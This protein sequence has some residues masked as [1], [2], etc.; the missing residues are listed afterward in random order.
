MASKKKAE[1]TGAPKSAPKTRA[2][3]AKAAGKRG[4][5]HDSARE[6]QPVAAP[7]VPAPTGK[8]VVERQIGGRTL[9]LET[10]RMAKLSDGAVVARYGDTMVLAAVNSAK[11]P[12]NIDFFPLT[13]D[14]REKTSAAGMIPGGF[15]KR[16]GR[17]TTKEILGSRLIDRSIRPMFPDGF[18]RDVQVL[19]QVLSTDRENDPDVVAAIASFAALA[20]SSLPHG[21]PLGMVRIGCLGDKLTINPLWSE[22]Q[23]ADNRLNL[24]VAGHKDAIVMVEAGAKEIS[25]ETMVEALDLAHRTVQEI[26]EMVEELAQKAGKPKMAYT[27]PARDEQLFKA[28]DAEFGDEL[29]AAPL[30]P[31]TKQVRS[32]ATKAAKEKVV[33]RF[34]APANATPDEAK[35][36]EKKLAG[37]LDDIVKGSERESILAGRRADGRDTK[38]VRPITIEVGVLPRVHGSVLFTRGETQALGVVTLGSPDDQQTVDGLMPEGKKRFL[39][40]YAFPPFSVGE[41]KKMLAPGRREIGH[42]ALAERGL[43]AVLPNREEFPYTI[44]ITSEILESNGSSSM[45]TACAGTL[46]MMDAG[47]KIK[48][49]VAGIAM[50]LVMEGKRYSILSDILGSEDACG[51]MDFKVVGTGRGI[52]ALQMDIKCDGLTRAIMSEALEQA[53]QGRLH[54]LR[55]MLKALRSPRQDISPNAPRLESVQVPSEKIG[56]IIGPGGKNIRSLQEQFECKIS[57]EDGGRCTIAG[58]NSE[59][60]KACLEHIRSMTAE[61]EL[62]AVYEGRVTAIKE[63]G[64]FVE[65]LPGQEGLVHVSE[66]SD[67]FIRAVTDVVRIGDTLKVKVIAID[68]FGKVKLSRKAILLAEAGGAAAPAAPAS[69]AADAP[70]AEHGE[71]RDRPMREERGPRADRPMREERGP[72]EDRPMR[73]ER[74][75]RADRPMR[76][77][78]GPREDRPMRD[79]RGP[80]EDRPMREERGPRADRPMREERGPREDRPMRDERG[81][82]EDRPMRDERGPRED[83]PMRDER[84]PRADRPMREERG[85]R[86]DRP[87]R[88]ERG[89]REDRPMREERSE[90][91]VPGRERDWGA[92]PAE[93]GHRE[94][95]ARDDERRERGRPPFADEG[96]PRRERSEGEREPR[97]PSGRDE[98]RFDRGERAEPA[99]RSERRPERG[100][101]DVGENRER[102][103]EPRGAREPRGRGPAEPVEPVGFDSEERRP[104]REAARPPVGGERRERPADR[105][106]RDDRPRGP[107]SA[108]PM[109]EFDD[110]APAPRAGNDV[111]ELESLDAVLGDRPPRRDGGRRGRRR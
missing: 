79:E 109:A 107:R 89:P 4:E 104:Q 61:I 25:E 55:E 21:M 99:E 19:S 36:W 64:A 98:P 49:P 86:A 22:L 51:D 27:P 32:A 9:S 94:P 35:A 8:V 1:D 12:D 5:H 88:E 45:A 2:P 111:G 7:A 40:H 53:K 110:E 31:G 24:T 84:G 16:E 108:M 10:G 46:A 44:R 83:R 39:L 63:F 65:I 106:G 30:T 59:K 105:G 28:I 75:P 48:Q 96:A 20:L 101:R 102:G 100:F 41:V 34:K 54:I 47:V 87:M 6:D 29:R 37:L 13:V 76:E 62:G 17:P 11:A 66:L 95:R 58:L 42:G 70:S 50:G 72:R 56:L 97:R 43:E 33:N 69:P 93:R 90:R 80:R 85:P 15:F 3:R 73:E 60:V 78:R 91:P 68:D 38:T 103:A 82:R 92:E 52:T 14:Y 23:S 77:E 74:G 26:V 67:G 18:R 71:R 57:I 81:P